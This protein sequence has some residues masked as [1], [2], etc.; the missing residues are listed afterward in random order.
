MR[1]TLDLPVDGPGRAQRGAALT[2]AASPAYAGHGRIASA[3]DDLG[4]AM[5]KWR[6]VSALCLV[7]PMPGAAMAQSPAPVMAQPQTPRLSD[8]EVLSNYFAPRQ[9]MLEMFQ[10]ACATLFRRRL[11]TDPGEI[12]VERR[13]PGI[14][15]A[16]V[17]GITDYCAAHLEPAVDAMLGKVQARI[18][19]DLTPA[20]IRLFADN[21]RFASE[22]MMAVQVDI[23]EGETAA[24]AARRSI[25]EANR[26]TARFDR[27][28]QALAATPAGATLFAKIIALNA[29]L[30]AELP[31]IGGPILNPLLK[32]AMNSARKSGNDYAV[33][34]GH[35]PVYIVD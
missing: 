33:R 21:F 32:A 35:R 31:S 30:Q 34:N 27:A 15:D 17:R 20:E 7:L 22:E 16:M 29:A 18:A 6:A 9:P 4:G 10:D 14:G 19:D 24:A 8:V 11:T 3:G 23:R 2:P 1:E 5:I 28:G 13:I 26:D 25:D 12:A